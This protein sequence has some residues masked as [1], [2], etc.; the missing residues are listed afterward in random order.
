MLLGCDR[1]DAALAHQRG[2]VDRLGD[3]DSALRWAEEI[4]E[5]APL[6]LAYSK[7]ALH[8]LDEPSTWEPLLDAAFDACWDSEDIAESKAAQAENRTPR[9]RGR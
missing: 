7:Q 8:T 3:T 1:V 9:F 4:A 6:S 2:L 5:L